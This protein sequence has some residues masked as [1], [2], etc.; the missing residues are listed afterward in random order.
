MAVQPFIFW[1]HYEAPAL[2]IGH[3]LGGAAVLAA[4]ARVPEARGVVTIGAPA[5]PEHVTALFSDARADI[6][7]DGEAE[8]VLAGRPFTIR[9]QLLDD[10]ASHTL[11]PAIAGLGTGVTLAI[12]RVIGETAPLLV[13]TGLVTSTNLNPFDGRMTTLPV[14]AFYQLTQPGFPPEPAIDRAWTAALVLIILVMALNVVARL[15]SRFFAPK[16]GR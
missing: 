5:D 3:S 4:A 16:T 14:F 13:T 1:I 7:R 9:K 6:E 8:V 11:E 10:L 15:I 12:A 2:L